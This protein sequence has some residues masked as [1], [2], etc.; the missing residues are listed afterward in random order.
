[1]SARFFLRLVHCWMDLLTT[2]PYS[3]VLLILPP[4]GIVFIHVLG[5]LSLF[6]GICLAWG[7]GSIVMKAALA[8]RPDAETQTQLAS[9]QQAA[10]QQASDMG[11]SPN[12][13]AQ[14]LIY[15]GF[16]LDTRVSVVACCLSCVFIYLMVSCRPPYSRPPIPRLFC[17]TDNWR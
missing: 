1:M 10:A 16:M 2:D 7:W 6:I 8:A 15:E 14:Q 3:L 4:A 5:Y 9:L 12:Y 13:A 11:T 17:T